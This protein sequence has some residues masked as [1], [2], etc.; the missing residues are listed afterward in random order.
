MLH[1]SVGTGLSGAAPSQGLTPR[2]KS[3]VELAV[4][5]ASRTGFKT[6]IIPRHGTG[7]VTAPDGMELL[8]VRNIREAIQLVLS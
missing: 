5:E 6:C 4:S 3:A 1:R 2:A 8:R 7:N